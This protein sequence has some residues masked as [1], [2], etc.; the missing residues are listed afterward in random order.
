MPTKSSTRSAHGRSSHS[1]TQSHASKRS[2]ERQGRHKTAEAKAN[3]KG[4]TNRC[5]RGYEPTPGKRPGAKG[6]CRKAPEG[7]NGSKG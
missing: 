7:K 2:P 1:S 4:S 5:W 6:S 3:R